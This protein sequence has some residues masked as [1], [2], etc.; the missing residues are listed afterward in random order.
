MQNI[1]FKQWDVFTD[2]ALGGNPLGIFPAASELDA[3]L[4]QQLTR[5]MNL[6]ECTFITGGGQGRYQVRIFTPERE[7]IF[8]GHPVVG[9]AAYIFANLEVGAQRIE[10]ELMRDV[11][12]VERMMLDGRELFCFSSPPVTWHGTLSDHALAARLVGLQPSQLAV[13]EFPVGLLDVGPTYCIIPLR[14]RQALEAASYDMAALRELVD[15]HGVDQLTVYC[16]VAYADGAQFSTRMF[17]PLHGVPEDPATG[18]SACCLASYL[19]RTK[20]LG[21]VQAEF[22]GL[23]QGYSMSRPSRIY[24]SVAGS[25]GSEVI[26]IAGQA[27][28][29]AGG[30]FRI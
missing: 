8:A 20:Q 17:A 9:T 4:M 22:H 14:D 19:A 30:E 23:D 13:D 24:F 28:E 16:P 11:V 7:M 18:S 10:L 21:A 15:R 2:R 5:E 6:S 12:P 3:G 25:P 29:V 26:R 27:L 1:A